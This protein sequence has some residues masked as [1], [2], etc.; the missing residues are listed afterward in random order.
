[1]L[2]INIGIPAHTSFEKVLLF[3]VPLLRPLLLNLVQWLARPLNDTIRRCE[4]GSRLTMD[5]IFWQLYPCW[6]IESNKPILELYIM[7]AES[8]LACKTH[9]DPCN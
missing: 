7:A 9:N 6:R 4:I 3:Q 1:M 8:S 2:V 5:H